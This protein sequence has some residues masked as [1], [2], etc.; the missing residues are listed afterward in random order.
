MNT[1]SDPI[2]RSHPSNIP[3]SN[4]QIWDDNETIL[5]MKKFVEIHVAL[6]DYKMML[7]NEAHEMGR[8]FTRHPMLHFGDDAKVRAIVD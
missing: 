8:P 7:M 3:E 2:M 5:F 1:F 6:A 4:F